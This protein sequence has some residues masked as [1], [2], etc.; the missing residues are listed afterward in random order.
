MNRLG[1]H[2]ASVAAVFMSFL[3]S[4]LAHELLM[5]SASGQFGT[6]QMTFF[7]LQALLLTVEKSSLGRQLRHTLL[8]YR[9]LRILTTLI[10]LLATSPIFFNGIG[11]RGIIHDAIQDVRTKLSYLTHERTL[12]SN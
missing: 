3:V 9:F 6:D 1:K 10:I 11:E 4:G 5:Y 2:L 7:L 12:Q 8:P